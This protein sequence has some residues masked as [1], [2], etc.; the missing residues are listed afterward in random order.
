MKNLIIK[1]TISMLIL[2]T[3][4]S[5][6]SYET[7][8][9]ISCYGVLPESGVFR[10]K[11]NNKYYYVRADDVG[12]TNFKLIYNSVVTARMKGKSISFGHGSDNMTDSNPRANWI[13]V[14]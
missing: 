5:F 12:M 8:G 7:S 10:F 1:I 3:V 14:W 13:T 6:A 2:F 11:V 4:S 9:T